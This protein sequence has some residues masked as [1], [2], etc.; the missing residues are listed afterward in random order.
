MPTAEAAETDAGVPRG[1]TILSD[2]RPGRNATKIE[3]RLY[4]FPHTGGSANFYVPFARAFN[5]GTKCVAVQYPGKRAGKDLSQ[6]TSIPDLADRLYAML[7]PA[8]ASR[9]QVAF[10]GHS[11]GSLLAFEVARRF[12]QAGD[13]IAAL[14]VSASAAPGMLRHRARLQGSDL[15]M[16][17]MVS[18]VTGANPEFLNNDQFAATLLPTLRGLKAIA[19]YD[20]PPEARLSSPIYGLMADNDELATTELMTPWALRTTSDFDLTTFP[21]DHFYINTNLPRLSHW[22]EERVFAR[23]FGAVPGG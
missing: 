6:Y 20:C 10:F 21:G 22:V 11:M 16:L 1:C 15:E 19:S 4:I 8:G 12:E 9:S 5:G 18:D 14:F 7:E 13:P 23:C 3:P 2:V 17:S